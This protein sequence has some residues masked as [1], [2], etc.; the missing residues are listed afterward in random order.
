MAEPGR[1][2][3]T[4]VAVRA[5]RHQ[6]T[7]VKLR[8][9][10]L[11]ALR[12]RL[13]ALGARSEGRVH[14]LNTLFDTPDHALARRGE[15]VRLRIVTDSRHRRRT[16]LTFKGSAGARGPYKVREE[17]EQEVVNP[18]V[19]RTALAALRLQPFFQYEKFRTT[20]RL[21]G[22][23]DVLVEV[24]ETPIGNFVELEGVPA[25]IDRAAER[26]GYSRSEYLRESYLGLYLEDCRR[27]QRVPSDMLFTRRAARRRIRR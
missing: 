8:V 17:F 26:L 6:E 4:A 11:S 14:E 15:L 19:F 10:N 27:R 21:P 22:L 18:E 13:R 20:F 5:H 24:D 16:L 25:A 7:E 1:A 3:Y 2:T 9:A 23:S 12:R